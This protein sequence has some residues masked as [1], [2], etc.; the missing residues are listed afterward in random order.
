MTYTLHPAIRN[1]I[2]LIGRIAAAVCRSAFHDAK[3]RYR[4]MK[5]DREDRAKI[6]M[7]QW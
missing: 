7:A 1:E 2:S 5:K 4:W 3:R 6:A